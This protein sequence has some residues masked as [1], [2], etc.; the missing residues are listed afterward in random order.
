MGDFVEFAHRL[1]AAVVA[2]E[3]IVGQDPV[4]ADEV[5]DE[6]APFV[7]ALADDG[8]HALFLNT[9]LA[10]HDIFALAAFLRLSPP[11]HRISDSDADFPPMCETFS[12][13]SVTE[14]ELDCL[15][16]PPWVAWRSSTQRQILRS[17]AQDY[18]EWRRR[19][20][21][22]IQLW[23]TDP[24]VE[25][26]P[27]FVA[28]V[29]ALAEFRERALSLNPGGDGHALFPPERVRAL[30]RNE[31]LARTTVIDAVKARR[32]LE[33]EF[34]TRL[35]L[36]TA[37]LAQPPAGEPCLAIWTPPGAESL[38]NISWGGVEPRVEFLDEPTSI[39]EGQT[40]RLAQLLSGEDQ[41]A[42]YDAIIRRITNALGARLTARSWS[43]PVLVPAM[44]W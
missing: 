41:A 22:T 1:F 8:G 14:Q 15:V 21:R 43:R 23:P 40:M 9:L 39:R 25:R 3:H 16:G 11:R 6:L 2:A 27:Q 32:N 13:L 42:A 36:N 7:G 18:E 28:T 12:M 37:D 19:S 31:T 24:L 29:M 10:T 5:P 38:V 33:M 17:E 30:L 4:P 34:L 44:S 35:D 20:D 26:T